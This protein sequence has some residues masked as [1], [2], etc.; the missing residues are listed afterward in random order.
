MNTLTDA[1]GMSGTAMTILAVSTA[2]LWALVLI[3]V[4]V[5]AGQPWRRNHAKHVLADRF[6]RGDIEVDEYQKR[7]QTLS[8]KRG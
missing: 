6:A 5:W 4:V 8:G 3:A 2:M 7:L 1:A